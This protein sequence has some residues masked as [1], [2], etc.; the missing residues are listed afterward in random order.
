MGQ[1]QS[2][3]M[4]NK[5]VSPGLEETTAEYNKRIRTVLPRPPTAFTQLP[6]IVI[7][8][9]CRYTMTEDGE[10]GTVRGLAELLTV[11]PSS[12]LVGV[13]SIKTLCILNERHSTQARWNFRVAKRTRTK[14][15]PNAR[16][17]RTVALERKIPEWCGWSR[18]DHHGS[19][20][21]RFL[22]LDPENYYDTPTLGMIFPN[23]ET[24]LGCVFSPQTLLEWGQDIRGYCAKTGYSIKPTMGGVAAQPLRDPQYYPVARRKVPAATNALVRPHLVGNHV[25]VTGRIYDSRKPGAVYSGIYLDQQRAHHF[26]AAQEGLL[27]DANS[28]YAFG[29]FVDCDRISF[30]G[31]RADRLLDGAFKGIVCG[32]FSPPKGKHRFV[33]P[34]FKPG[35]TG[36]HFIFTSEW[37]SLRDIGVT[38]EGIA[39]AWGSAHSDTG[40]PK[41]ARR[42]IETLEEYGNPAWLKPILLATYGLLATRPS[43]STSVYGKVRRGHGTPIRFRAYGDTFLHGILLDHTKGRTVEPGFANV[44]H[45]GLIEAATRAEVLS[46]A[47]HLEGMGYHVLMIHADGLIVEVNDQLPL[48]LLL[49]P[50]RFKTRLTDLKFIN[51]SSF[52][53]VQME[54]LPGQAMSGRDWVTASRGTVGGKHGK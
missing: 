32:D 27:P 13:R 37:P 42:S 40:I 38:C 20:A 8:D 26:H 15:V 43:E 30:Q 10:I 4:E 23:L 21:K 50:W 33:P 47:N 41:Y 49:P 44:I 28:L 31:R 16:Q 48:P 6:I 39:A 2:G 19:L 34:E 52:T 29:D 11:I 54:R 53:S 46:F 1:R 51:N 5:R 36:R 14:Y 7:F 18:S 12:L 24:G 35:K 45:R 9:G 22:F 25:E 17:G 3:K